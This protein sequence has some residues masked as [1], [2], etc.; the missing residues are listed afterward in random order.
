MSSDP[1]RSPSSQ[2]KDAATEHETAAHLHRVA[3]E[4]LDHNTLDAARSSSRTA[5][6]SCIRANG[7]SVLAC[8]QSDTPAVAQRCADIRRILDARFSL[9]GLEY[10]KN[11]HKLWWDSPT[12]DMRRGVYEEATRELRR[13]EVA[14]DEELRSELAALNLR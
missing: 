7:L 13:L 1:I 4:F 11:A 9:C 2:H 14:G 10:L 6:E 8:E 3:A 12:N 5:L